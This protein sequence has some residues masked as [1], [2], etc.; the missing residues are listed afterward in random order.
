MASEKPR[1]LQNN[2]DMLWSLIPLALCCILLAGIASQCSFSPGGPTAGPVPSFDLD[3]ALKYDSQ[4][5]DFPVRHPETPEGWTPNSGSRS[6][7]T[8]EY[9]GD[10]ST[11][12]FITPPGRYIQLTQSEAGESALVSFVAGGPR[13]A[14]GAEEIAGRHWVVYGGDGVEPIW[15]S[16]FGDVRLLL[17]GSA[18]EESFVTLA[19]AVSDAEILN[20]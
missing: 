17:T 15:V 8:G 6:V 9:G 3:A 13:T 7:V 19:T 11:V 10:S 12:G 20:D 5:L 4:D 1:I 16:D 14:S 18:D 2:R